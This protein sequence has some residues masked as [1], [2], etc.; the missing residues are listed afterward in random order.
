MRWKELGQVGLGVKGRGGDH[1]SSFACSWTHSI[2]HRACLMERHLMKSWGSHNANTW[3]ITTLSSSL[4]L[5]PPI[6]V[7][8][9][10]ESMDENSWEAGEDEAD[11][12]SPCFHSC[13]D[14][15]GK[16]EGCLNYKYYYDYMVV[17]SGE[18]KR[19]RWYL[20]WGSQEKNILF[21][22]FPLSLLPEWKCA[23]SQLWRQTL[24][25]FAVV[26][27]RC[28]PRQKVSETKGFFKGVGTPGDQTNWSSKTSTLWRS[29]WPA[30]PALVA[31][32]PD[33]VFPRANE[34]IVHIHATKTT[35][36]V[37]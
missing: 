31:Q 33:E 30:K 19:R 36:R 11:K 9:R 15:G 21:L 37:H 17:C 4:S 3:W 35:T 23:V 18:W 12:P 26:A 25:F 1:K 27:G 20:C 6:W 2:W 22:P 7:R 5:S 28:F 8:A 13:T 14:G 16:G 29:R 24:S 10:T 32:T 34:F